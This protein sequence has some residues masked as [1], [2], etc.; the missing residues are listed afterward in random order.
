MTKETAKSIKAKLLNIAR[1]EKMDYQVLLIRYLYERLLYRLSISKFRE[2]FCLKGG[3]LL[4]AFEKELP[5]PT[6]DI[7]FLG[8][9]IKN[10]VTTIKQVFSEI[11]AISCEND[12]IEFDITSI[13]TEEIIENKAYEG[14]RVTYTAHLDSIRQIQKIDIGFGDVVVPT[15]QSLPYPVLMSDLPVPNILAYSLETVVAEKFQAMID[16]GEVN[17]RYKDFYD[18]YQILTQQ[19]LDKK[20]LTDAIRATFH[21]RKTGYKGNHPLFSDNFAKDTHRNSQWKRFLKRIKRNENLDFETV[22]LLIKSE[23]QPIFENNKNV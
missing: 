14:I 17:S 20:I 22:M 19:K 7:D 15:A 5:R 16:L 9:K 1:K 13:S 8:I 10:D 2:H 6:L 3:A 23:L 21:N 4:Y 18:V 11:L 12:G